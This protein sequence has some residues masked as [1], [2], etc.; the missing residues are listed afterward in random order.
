MTHEQKLPENNLNTARIPIFGE[1]FGIWDDTLE[2]LLAREKFY[3]FTIGNVF[4]D[5]RDYQE[6][7]RRMVRRINDCL[8][9]LGLTTQ[10][11]I[12]DSFVE[13]NDDY[14]A[15]TKEMLEIRLK[16]GENIG[17]ILFTRVYSGLEIETYEHGMSETRLVFNLCANRDLCLDGSGDFWTDRTYLHPITNDEISSWDNDKV[18]AIEDETGQDAPV[19]DSQIGYQITIKGRISQK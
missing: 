3:D 5:N 9:C 18:P 13:K 14:P 19:T 12:V 16:A 15:F 17:N 6:K 7:Y 10:Q 11:Q 8:T 1:V 4:S 2:N